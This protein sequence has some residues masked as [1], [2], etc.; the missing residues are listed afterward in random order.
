SEAL[1]ERD[2]QLGLAAR[3]RA[4]HH[5]EL[6]GSGGSEVVVED[7]RRC[8]HTLRRRTCWTAKQ[9]GDRRPA[10]SW[11]SYRAASAR[12]CSGDIPSSLVSAS[13]MTRARAA[14]SLGTSR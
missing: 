5:Q 1:G 11:T 13:R 8:H 6:V 12:H 10:S 2:R 9:K 3:G 7:G 4:H 14:L